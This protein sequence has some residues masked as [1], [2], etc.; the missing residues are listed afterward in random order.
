MSEFE[1]TH[2]TTPPRAV[3]PR[4]RLRF[5]GA[6]AVA[7]VALVAAGC[8]AGSGAPDAT[9]PAAAPTTT[10]PPR[11]Y[12]AAQVQALV[13]FYSAADN[14][15]PGS[16]DIAHPSDRHHTAG[17]TGAFDDP[18]TMATDVREIPVGGV[19]YSPKLQR[20]FVMEDDCAPCIAEWGASKKAH[21]AFWIG[22][23]TDS[24]VTAC[25]DSLTSARPVTIQYDPPP[26]LTVDTRP[27]YS[28]GKCWPA[29]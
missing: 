4:R 22:G 19:V 16:T 14:D 25:E 8:S 3:G 21:V 13:T 10:A 17:G 28:A 15:P 26:G 12:A 2:G 24:R 18:I 23:G 29:T 7:A 5:L 9:T 6:A 11:A 20:Y 27:L 1:S